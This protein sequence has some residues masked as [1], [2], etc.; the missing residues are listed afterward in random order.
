MFPRS[1]ASLIA[2]G[3]VPKI[4]L[5][6]VPHRL[7]AFRWSGEESLVSGIGRDV[8]NYEISGD[9]VRSKWQI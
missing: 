5:K 6:L 7:G 8:A 3:V 4:G 9:G 2:K 1:C